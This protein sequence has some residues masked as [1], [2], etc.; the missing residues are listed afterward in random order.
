[1]CALGTKGSHTYQKECARYVAGATVAQ[2]QRAAR[3]G[4]K[5]RH[6]LLLELALQRQDAEQAREEGPQEK[7]DNPSSSSSSSSASSTPNAIQ[8]RP[9]TK[10]TREHQGEDTKTRKKQPGPR[11]TGKKPEAM[12]VNQQRRESPDMV[13]EILGWKAPKGE[14]GQQMENTKV[15]TK[16]D[17]Q[18]KKTTL[19]GNT[20]EKKKE[21]KTQQEERRKMVPPPASA[22]VDESKIDAVAKLEEARKAPQRVKDDTPTGSGNLQPQTRK[23]IAVQTELGT[24]EVQ[25]KEW[26]DNQPNRERPASPMRPGEET[27][28]E[29]GASAEEIGTDEEKRQQEGEKS[30]ARLDM[31]SNDEASGARTQAEPSRTGTGNLPGALAA[32]GRYAP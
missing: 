5:G 9:S 19:S 4:I 18:T 27:P 3:G 20:K 24:T 8:S 15:Q 10:R 31:E 30:G 21:E 28:I 26:K 7:G 1:M 22:R 29:G 25:K 32:E 11:D 12:T 2:M 13:E 16:E 23:E 17:N 14:T 6:R